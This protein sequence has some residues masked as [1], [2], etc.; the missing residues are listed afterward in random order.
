MMTV[1]VVDADHLKTSAHLLVCNHDFCQYPIGHFQ[2]YHNTLYTL[3]TLK[4][5]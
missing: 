5:L 1:P 4:R 2:K 3:I